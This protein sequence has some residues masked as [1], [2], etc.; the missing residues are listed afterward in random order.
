MKTYLT[1]CLI[2]IF[3]ISC[4]TRKTTQEEK[5]EAGPKNSIKKVTLEKVWSTDTVF[6][7]PES[8][9]YDPARNVIYVSNIVGDPG[10]VDG[11]G[12]ISRLHPD[13]TIID[14]EWIHDLNA[15]K[16]MGV[17]KNFLYVADISKVVV[18]DIGE[19]KVVENYEIPGAAFLN[20]I[21]IDADGMV[22][23]SDSH[24]SKIH[25]IRNGEIETWMEGAPL[26]GPNG[27]FCEKDWIMIASSGDQQVKK[28]Q[29]DNREV[30]V[31]TTEI[32]HGD[33]IVKDALGN[34]VVSDWAGQIFYISLGGEKTS[35]LDTRDQQINSADIG[36]VVDNNLLLVP[37]FL[38]N[39][40]MAYRLKTE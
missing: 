34:Y 36:L 10:T 18:I 11:E 6:R 37:T 39:R 1:L 14:L 13:G 31:I 29:K 12:F 19:S 28:V 24:L 21:S 30:M 38:D 32:G 15:P 25:L 26:N 8:V 17:F 3:A 4:N 23:V 35:L 27:L 33:G 40:V 9:C 2:L 16:G 5:P 22:Y 20:D 7:V